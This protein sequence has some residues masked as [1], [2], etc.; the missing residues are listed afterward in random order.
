MT[1]SR[2]VRVLLALFGAVS[3]SAA[4]AASQASAAA[5]SALPL[6][7]TRR[8]E[9]TTTEG[10]DMSVDVSPNGKSIVFDLLGDIYM[11]PAGGGSARP[12]VTGRS[13]D[14]YPRISPD[15]K[16]IAFVSDRDGAQNLWTA[17]VNGSNLQRVSN[18]SVGGGWLVTSPAWSPDSRKLAVFVTRNF[19]W[20]SSSEIGELREYQV[21]SGE[22]EVL[23]ADRGMLDPTYS[24]DGKSIFVS[25]MVNPAPGGFGSVVAFG[26]DRI[27]P[28]FQ[29]TILD[30]ATRDLKPITSGV[31]GGFTPSIS[32]DGS[33]LVYG[34]RN[35]GRTGLRA[36][37]LETGHDRWLTSPV[38]LDQQDGNLI[39]VQ[40][41]SA[42]TPNGKELI[43]S[44][45]GKLVRVDLKSGHKTNVPFS[46]RVAQELAPLLK[47]PRSADA[48]KKIPLRHL[49]HARLS[50][51]G[52]T[53]AF[54]AFQKIWVMP[55]RGGPV[56][57]VSN[58][59]VAEAMPSWSD[60]SNTLLFSTW[61]DR[62]GGHIYQAD[63]RNGNLKAVTHDTA[64]YV[65]PTY[66]SGG[67]GII[68]GRS[69]VQ[70]ADAAFERGPQP[71]VDLVWFKKA[72]KRADLVARLGRERIGRL[73]QV[74]GSNRVFYNVAGRG[75]MSVA[76]GGGQKAELQVR[77]VVRRG[78]DMFDPQVQDIQLSPSGREALAWVDSSIYMFPVPPARDAGTASIYDLSSARKLT[79]S[80][81]YPS[82]S[83]TGA[84]YYSVGPIV[85]QHGTSGDE[86]HKVPVRIDL[87]VA[88]ST[89]RTLLQNARLIT[90][91]GEEVI[92]HGDILIEGNRIVAH[93]KSGSFPS[94]LVAGAR[95]IDL[96]GHTILPGFVDNHCHAVSGEGASELL[97]RP[98]KRWEYE[99]YLAFGVTTCRDPYIAFSITE[100]A[101]LIA[102]GRMVG[103]RLFTT[104][105]GH[106]WARDYKTPEQVDE[107][108]EIYDRGYRT[109][110]LKEYAVGD[111]M[112]EQWFA[113]SAAKREMMPTQEGN[114]LHSRLWHLID[115]YPEL[116]HALPISELH[117]DVRQ[118]VVASGTGVGV[119]FG[120]LRLEGAPSAIWHFASSEGV[121]TDPKIRKFV[122]N[123]AL[124][125]F[126]RR[127]AIDPSED[128]FPLFAK[129]YRALLE[130]GATIALSDHGE[131][132]GVGMHWEIFAL[133]SA[134]NNHAALKAATAGGAD[135]LALTDVGRIG[136]GLLADLI[137]V[138][139]NPLTDIKTISKLR[140]VMKDGQLFDADTLSEAQVRQ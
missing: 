121:L 72:S 45:G 115:G 61:E 136:P 17:D 83:E 53:L 26:N 16:R 133:A 31:G 18:L 12:L 117:D 76:L 116:T 132:K 62:T 80:G 40:P 59:N 91:R 66:L 63:L 97:H 64:H 77:G 130:A 111:R 43:T 20:F 87:P 96:S 22:Y 134:G 113:L 58:L 67:R 78:G 5:N 38:D 3:I 41:K 47:F 104:G 51:D 9:F 114:G 79:N 123:S 124:H 71:A 84:V 48:G 112:Q 129:S 137:V 13:Y 11:V 27:L 56:R 6:A 106:T 24:P 57:R 118:L 128:T 109:H 90:M 30:L 120:T 60:D 138:P 70:D 46:A 102:S 68:A 73:Q 82:W 135:I 42:F 2:R 32:P 19:E 119:Q 105:P 127:L 98:S 139:G 29:V 8:V 25:G 85:V 35:G 69:S 44:I 33:Q 4:N 103:P 108:F 140:F 55:A 37:N 131:M 89:A 86:V 95:S 36:R 101:D 21:P 14:L 81:Q 94:K 49:R 28:W 93:G 50:P 10:T 122:P 88:R 110:Y 23:V 1:I 15:G 100:D 7:G 107:A 34:S 126:R 52:K 65:W 39:Y 125:R 99:A 92:E 74:R 75:L 54:G